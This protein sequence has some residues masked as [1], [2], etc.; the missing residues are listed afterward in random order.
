MNKYTQGT[1]AFKA[2]SPAY[3]ILMPIPQTQLE[4]N[5]LLKQNAGY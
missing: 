2:P 1:W 5:L 3:K 4:T